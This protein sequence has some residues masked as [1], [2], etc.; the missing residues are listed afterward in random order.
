MLFS[1]IIMNFLTINLP[2]RLYLLSDFSNGFFKWRLEKNAVLNN[3]EKKIKLVQIK[4]YLKN[5]IKYI[6]RARF[7][8]V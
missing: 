8:L 6:I 2:L 5:K 1:H 3:L 4:L 7:K